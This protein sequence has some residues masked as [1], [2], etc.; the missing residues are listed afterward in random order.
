MRCVDDDEMR[1]VEGI[2]KQ[3][4]WKVVEDDGHRVL[5]EIPEDEGE[6]AQRVIEDGDEEGIS[7]IEGGPILS[8]PFRNR[9]LTSLNRSSYVVVPLVLVCK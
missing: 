9:V 4:W 7:Q 1:E 5:R 8:C 6:R 2:G 3:V